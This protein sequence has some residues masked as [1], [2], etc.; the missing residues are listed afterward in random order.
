MSKIT[1]RS[2]RD[3]YRTPAAA[4][5]DAEEAFRLLRT[6]MMGGRI[7]RSTTTAMTTWMYLPIFGTE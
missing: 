4:D 5:E 3:I 7:D 2:G 6:P 1:A